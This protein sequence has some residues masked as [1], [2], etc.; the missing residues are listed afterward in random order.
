M[1]PISKGTQSLHAAKV[2]LFAAP[3]LEGKEVSVVI[4]REAI[5]G[6]E[7]SIIGFSASLWEDVHNCLY[8]GNGAGCCFRGTML[9]WVF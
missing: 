5:L 4:K 7:I 6:A 1:F 9:R 8:P 3:L 2:K